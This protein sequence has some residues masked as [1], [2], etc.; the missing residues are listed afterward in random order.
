[1]PRYVALLRGINVTGR[2]KVAMA[3]LKELCGTLGHT[4]VVTYVQSGNIVFSSR[5]QKPAV[6]AEGIEAQ[7]SKDL[8]LDVR[9]VIR[10]P[11]DLRKVI[12]RNPFA[13]AKDAPKSLYVTFLAA[14]PDK[15]RVGAL[16]SFE[17]PPDEFAVDGLHVYL[18]CPAG[19]GRSKLNNTFW[20]R[21]LAVDATTRN[22]NTINACLELASGA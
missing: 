10:T 3:D 5:S 15:A 9:V 4:G 19:Y 14:A 6:I 1:M 22:W 17:A 20:E 7:I 13:G 8:G 2:N 12:Q 18:H 16:D 11:A 21:K